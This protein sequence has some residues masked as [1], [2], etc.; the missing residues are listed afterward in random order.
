MCSDET[1]KNQSAIWTAHIFL[2][3][4]KSLQSPFE[5]NSNAYKRCLSRGLKR[6]VAVDGPSSE[7]FASAVSQAFGPLLQNRPWAPLQ[8]TLRDA[9]HLQELLMLRPLGPELIG[10]KYDL[11]FLRAQC[12]VLDL[13]GKIYSVYI[14]L[15]HSTLSWDFLRTSPVVIPG[16]EASWAHDPMLDAD[17]SFASEENNAEYN[18]P[19]AENLGV[20]EH[21]SNAV[22]NGIPIVRPLAY[23]S[24][25]GFE[26]SSDAWSSI[27]SAD[28]IEAEQVTSAA[29]D[30][31]ASSTRRPYHLPR[32]LDPDS[33]GHN[34]G[35]DAVW[36]R[37]KRNLVSAQVLQEAGLHYKARPDYVAVLGVL[38]REEITELAQK[39]AEMRASR[40]GEPPSKIDDQQSRSA[41]AVSPDSSHPTNPSS[42]A[43][44]DSTIPGSTT[45][46]IRA[47]YTD[48]STLDSFFGRLFGNGK[49]STLVRC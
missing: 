49:V 20:I 19:S 33:R 36:T 28:S 3:P 7:A 25:F 37:I 38:S 44:I 14:A 35:P 1:S 30:S 32:Q 34:I 16:L 4:N 45:I 11:E 13:K 15:L 9:D 46:S 18:S 22:T 47:T 8:A 10:S 17:C 31:S 6:E 24:G 48:Q 12:A 23:H 29:T 43:S 26:E 42:M 39:S 21:S 41:L 40:E 27:S 5:R 2:M